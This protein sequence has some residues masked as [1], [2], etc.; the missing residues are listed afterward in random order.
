MKKLFP[1]NKTEHCMEKRYFEKY[2]LKN[3]NTERYKKSSIPSMIRMLNEEELMKCVL[4]Q[5]IYIMEWKI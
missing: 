5:E 2:F 1:L 3:I 4:T